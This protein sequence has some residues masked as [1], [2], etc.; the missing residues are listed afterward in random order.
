MTGLSLG[1]L[2]V[3]TAGFSH[4]ALFGYSSLSGG[5]LRKFRTENSRA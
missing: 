3:N 2:H 1:S 4:P 5:F